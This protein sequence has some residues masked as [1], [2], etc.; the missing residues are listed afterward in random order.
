MSEWPTPYF[1]SSLNNQ[2]LKRFM[3][4][5]WWVSY[6]LWGP[7]ICIQKHNNKSEKYR[8]LRKLFFFFKD[9]IDLFLERREGREKGKR[10]VNVWLPLAC[11]LLGTWPA[12]QA[13]ALTGNR[14]ND[15]LVCR[16]ALNPLSHI[17]QARSYIFL[18]VWVSQISLTNINICPRSDKYNQSCVNKSFPSCCLGGDSHGTH[19]DVIA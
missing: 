6:K 14:T 19:T 12:T 11:P 18:L 3:A 4:C 7:K 17:S 8:Q 10:N 15:P 16:L 5:G 9:C 13:C 2:P 1:H